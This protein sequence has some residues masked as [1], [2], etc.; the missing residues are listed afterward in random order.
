MKLLFVF[1][2]TLFSFLS[3]ET[4]IFRN[5]NVKK[6][7][8]LSQ[9]KLTIVFEEKE[10]EPPLIYSKKE[11]LKISVKDLSRDEIN[12]TIA[13]AGGADLL[14]D[15][16][17][18]VP[19]VS[20]D[21]PAANQNYFSAKGTPKRWSAFWRSALIPGWGQLY[22]SR[23]VPGTSYFFLFLGG[24]GFAYYQNKEYGYQQN[25]YNYSNQKYVFSLFFSDNITQILTRKELVDERSDAVKAFHRAEIAA[26]VLAGIYALNLLDVVIFHPKY[27]VSVN[28]TTNR[29]QFAL[30]FEYRF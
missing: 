18:S 26:G 11:I 29:D 28:A 9:D 23:P 24:I 4:V 20:K 10:G 6:G 7:K 2:L 13:E 21:A 12:K 27:N 30:K 8:I 17:P 15:V 5:G 25:D 1:Y 14:Q 16:T 3:A 19:V 22:Q